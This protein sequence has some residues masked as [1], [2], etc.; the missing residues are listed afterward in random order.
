MKKRLAIM[1]ISFLIMAL[2]LFFIFWWQRQTKI[3]G[4]ISIQVNGELV[5]M[6]LIDITCTDIDGNI[7]KVNSAINKEGKLEF[8]VN[9]EEKTIYN[10]F[11]SLPR[12]VFDQTTMSENIVYRL[13][14]LQLVGDNAEGEIDISVNQVDEGEWE[15]VYEANVILREGQEEERKT[16]KSD[17][18]NTNEISLDFSHL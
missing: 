13:S 15:S 14:V 12:S 2:I 9:K 7:Y 6:S 3:K 8:H 1:S 11:F 4:S 10:L 5:D 18:K 17:L 16:T